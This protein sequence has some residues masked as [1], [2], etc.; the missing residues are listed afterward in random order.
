MCSEFKDMHISDPQYK[1]LE[2][3]IEVI[4]QTYMKDEKFIEAI[5]SSNNENAIRKMDETIRQ[6][7]KTRLR[8]HS[9]EM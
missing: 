2:K 5:K 4:A 8:G 7:E 3:G 9:M 1:T 6:Q